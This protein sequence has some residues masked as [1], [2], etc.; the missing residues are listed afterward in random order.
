MNNPTEDTESWLRTLHHKTGATYTCGQLE[1]GTEGTP[2]IQFFVNFSSPVRISKITKIEAKLHLEPVKINNGA[3]LYCMK[4]ESRVEGPFEFGTRPVQR[5][6]KTDWESVWTLAKKGDLEAVPAQIRVTHYSKLKVIAKDHMTFPEATGTTKGVW[7][8]GP[9]GCGKSS[10]ARSRY[11]GAYPKLCNKW[12][13][14]YQNQEAVIMDD[15]G[16]E[17][18]VLGQQ[19]KIWADHYPCILET[20]GGGIPATFK[21]L[22]VTS[23]Y[24]IEEIFSDPKTV[25]ALK[26]RFKVIRW[27][28]P[29]LHEPVYPEEE[30]L[31]LTKRVP[32]PSLPPPE[33]IARSPTYLN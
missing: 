1:L 27:A 4:D 29:D 2:H 22:V 15:L 6:N 20:K 32:L 25:D 31:P 7:I 10:L 12:W 14:G 21:T 23:Q 16:L 13:D 30:V 19:L 26:R 24:S 28:F 18:S 17:H 33:R 11:P 8:V 3:H 9:T 5:N